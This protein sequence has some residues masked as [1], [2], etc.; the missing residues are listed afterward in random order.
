MKRL[1]DWKGTSGKVQSPPAVLAEFTCQ[2]WMALS[3]LQG[4]FTH[5]DLSATD[6]HW[7]GA[8]GLNLTAQLASSGFNSR[9]VKWHRLEMLLKGLQANIGIGDKAAPLHARRARSCLPDELLCLC[10]SPQAN[11][12]LSICFQL[13]NGSSCKHTQLSIQTC[14]GMTL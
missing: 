7:P 3:N 13:S 10:R 12:R 2:T 6:S 11:M 1:G 9:R 14:T 4:V 5:I 8:N